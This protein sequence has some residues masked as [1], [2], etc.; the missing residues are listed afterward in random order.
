[1]GAGTQEPGSQPSCARGSWS[2]LPC[3]LSGD[4]DSRFQPGEGREP[5]DIPLLAHREAEKL[6][7]GACLGDGPS[8]SGPRGLHSAPTHA[9]GGPKS[10]PGFPGAQGSHRLRVGGAGSRHFSPQSARRGCSGAE[11]GL[12]EALDTSECPRPEGTLSAVGGARLQSL[13]K[14]HRVPPRR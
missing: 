10:V 5:S 6:P 2:P 14:G 8:F 1:M 3:A 12:S 7:Q 9:C 4:R 11:A 13:Q